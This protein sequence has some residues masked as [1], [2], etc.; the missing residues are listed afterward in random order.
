MA[1]TISDSNLSKQKLGLRW[2]LTLLVV[3]LLIA[4]MPHFLDLFVILEMSRFFGLALLA[5]SMGFLWGY[6]GMLSFGQTAF[7][8]IGGYG[9]TILA[10]NTGETT[11]SM[12]FAA[13]AGMP[14]GPS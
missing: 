6:G 14:R 11:G 8:G 3:G 2:W 9:Y 1:F 4:I 12:F 10:I 5:L 13:A 7:F